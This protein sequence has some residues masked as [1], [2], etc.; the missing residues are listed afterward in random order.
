MSAPLT[1]E[2]RKLKE[3]LDQ[4]TP[5]QRGKFHMIFPKGCP[6]RRSY[7]I[8]IDLIERTIRKNEQDK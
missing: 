8:A 6:D 1:K 4:C 2:E 5:E 7:K 3:L